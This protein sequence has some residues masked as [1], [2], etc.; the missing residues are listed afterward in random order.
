MECS[1][2]FNPD[3]QGVLEAVA[4]V[5]KLDVTL[6]DD[7]LLR[8][9]GTGPY[10]AR[11]GEQLHADSAFGQALRSGQPVRVGNPRVD[12]ICHGCGAFTE[13]R[14]SAHIATPILDGRRCIGVLGLIAFTRPQ[15]EQLLHGL[16]AYEGFLNKISQLIAG[17]FREEKAVRALLEAQGYLHA[18]TNSVAEGLVATDEDGNIT[19]LNGPA[20]H[21][22]RLSEQAA[23]AGIRDL[24][25]LDAPL[26]AV[27]ATGQSCSNQELAVATP[28]G[29]VTVV[30]NIQ[31]IRVKGQVAGAV[32]SLRDIEDVYDLVSRLHLEPRAPGFE[33][34]MYRSQAMVEVVAQARRVAAGQSTVLIRGESGTGKELFARALHTC[35]PRREHPFIAINCAAI[36]DELLESELFGYSEGAFTGARRG[37][38]P[39]RLELAHRGTL[40]L[41]E[42][43]DMSLRV[44]A[45]LLRVLQEPEVTR[46]GGT[47]VT[48][49]DVRIIA[50]T[51]Q[52]L[53]ALVAR[54]AFREDL[55]FR[56][57]VIPIEIPPLRARP[58]DILLL[59]DNCR[60][61]KGRLLNK[62]VVAFSGEAERLLLDYHWPGNVRELENAV[63]YAVA[64]AQ[65]PVAGVECLPV[66]LRKSSGQRSPQKAADTLTRLTDMEERELR[67]G[68]LLYGS[69][70]KAVERMAAD[71]GVSRATVYRRLRKYGLLQPGV[72]A[73]GAAPD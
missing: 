25:G 51:H 71:L 10:Q 24:P 70:G 35:S 12:S 33:R 65:G 62:T 2:P 11:R 5:L 20:R 54:Q 19:F 44:Q 13:C 47:G 46:V 38:K 56:L 23:L 9:A 32:A 42:V 69:G 39:G 59:A 58:E 1:V 50:A 53:E 17:Q 41:D 16:A 49:L 55:Y 14:E 64:M 40:F 34:I 28:Q 15:R 8:T 7:Q 52:N 36:P 73:P 3:Y 29:P 37:G 63:E 66:W 26:R 48:R 6:V 21:L 27:L 68:L 45:K 18:V 43:G 4:A 61:Q 31:P 60:R 22:F 67:R 72:A 30:A 57:N